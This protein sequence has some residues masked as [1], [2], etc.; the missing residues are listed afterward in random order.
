LAAVRV[1]R[2]RAGQ[3]DRA[4]AAEPTVAQVELQQ[5]DKATLAVRA[6]ATLLMTKNMAAGAEVQARRARPAA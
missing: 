6:R 3:A 5:P 1:A 2:A 4:E